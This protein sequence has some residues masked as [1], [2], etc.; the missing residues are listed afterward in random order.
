MEPT[1]GVTHH[2]DIYG[3][4]QLEEDRVE[5][6]AFD[7]CEGSDD[8]EDD[9]EGGGNIDETPSKSRRVISGSGSGSRGVIKKPKCKSSYL[10][11]SASTT[12]KMIHAD[13]SRSE[14]EAG[15]Q[16]NPLDLTSEADENGNE[17][18]TTAFRISPRQNARHSVSVTPAVSKENSPDDIK[19]HGDK[20]SPITTS[21]S[22]LNNKRNAE[23]FSAEKSRQHSLTSSARFELVR[24]QRRQAREKI[25]AAC[26]KARKVKEGARRDAAAAQACLVDDDDDGDALLG[27]REPYVLV[28]RSEAPDEFVDFTTSLQV[29]A[30]VSS[31]SGIAKSALLGKKRLSPMK[32]WKGEDMELTGRAAYVFVVV[33]E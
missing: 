32:N 17:N 24:K 14:P 28:E 21:L 26:G 22:D 5:S 31:K 27:S 1:A 12:D 20:S 8:D 29:A 6:Y 23:A 10:R 18:E 15:N 19:G 30:K 16:D 3:I 25:H 4:S 13:K 9:D 11:A 2:E 33:G 7:L